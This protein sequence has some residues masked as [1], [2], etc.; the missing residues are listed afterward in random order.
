[1][2][3]P[4]DIK[5]RKKQEKWLGCETD[6]QGSSKLKWCEFCGKNVCKD[7]LVKDRFFP[8][9]VTWFGKWC[10]IWDRKFYIDELFA[11]FRV[12]LDNIKNEEIG[13]K[14]SIKLKEN[15]FNKYNTYYNDLLEKVDTDSKSKNEKISVLE[16]KINTLNDALFKTKVEKKEIILSID[17]GFTEIADIEQ[18]LKELEYKKVEID[19]AIKSVDFKRQKYNEEL[20]KLQQQINENYLNRK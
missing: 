18:E 13:L 7:C 9:D 12:V 16:F 4:I 20:E 10:I 8:K 1:M 5:Y 6:I 19:Q 17:E 11:E 15:E 14:Q 2:K 3:K